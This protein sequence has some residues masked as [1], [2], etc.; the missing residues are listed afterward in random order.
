MSPRQHLVEPGAER[1][2]QLLLGAGVEIGFRR[3]FQH[4]RSHP[5]TAQ[6][7]II[8]GVEHG[9]HVARNDAA[10]GFGQKSHENL[11]APEHGTLIKCGRNNG[12][13]DQDSA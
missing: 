8:S 11:L 4:R 7:R 6:Q 13:G 5:R 3:P 10:R 12:F 2:E 1:F 9:N